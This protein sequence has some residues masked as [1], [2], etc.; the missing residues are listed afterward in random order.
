VG[1]NKILTDGEVKQAMNNFAFAI[2]EI[3]LLAVTWGKINDND[4]Y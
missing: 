3:S 1:N 2:Q 4:L